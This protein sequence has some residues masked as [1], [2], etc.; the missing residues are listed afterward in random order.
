MAKTYVIHGNKE[1]SGE[2]TISGSKNCA[3]CLIAGALIVRDRVILENIPNIKDIEMFCKILNYLNVETIYENNTLIIDSRNLTKKSLCIDEVKSFRASYYL[4][5]ALVNAF[6]T[7]EI[8]RSGGCNF[9]SRPINYHLD[10]L[11]HFGVDYVERNNNYYFD[12]KE[13]T[14]DVYTLA[15][16]S[17]GTTINALLFALTSNR[18]IT[19]KNICTEIEVLHFI[20]FLKAMGGKITYFNG[21]AIIE[22]SSLH[23]VR[24]KNIPDRIETG[25]FLLMGPV[26][27]SY[28]K[29]NKMCPLHSRE[30][31]DLFSLLDIDYTLGDDYVILKKTKIEKSCL[32]ETG[33]GGHISSDLQPLLT[34]FCLAIPRISV[35]KEKVYSSRFTHIEPLKKMGG[36]ISES[37]QNI[38]INGIM[39]L[40]GQ[41]ITATDL[42]MAASMIF[43]SLL[44]EGKSIIHHMDYIDRGYE[45]IVEK[46]N[47]LG[48]D[49][50]VYED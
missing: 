12:V 46:L 7:L 28:L 30:L 33:L 3:L 27:C 47:A 43:A 45:N 24:F 11:S 41:E 20:D 40:Q 36:F 5:G 34:V 18:N 4:I 22:K 8:S 49:I 42:R 23:G 38:L 48:A 6:K 16:P 26:V 21:T 31:L 15:Y 17:F 35:I 14:N 50:K 10:M 2:V 1:L 25:T 37:N 39:N 32:V 29:I 44:A 9:V 19:L 13:N